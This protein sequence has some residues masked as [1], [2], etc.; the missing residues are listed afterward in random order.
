MQ[1]NVMCL[2]RMADTLPLPGAD[3]ILSGW[4]LFLKQ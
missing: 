1:G 4:L 2:R 3:I